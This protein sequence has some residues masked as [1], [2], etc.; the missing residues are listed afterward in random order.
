MWECS[1]FRM[2]ESMTS[3]DV[4]Q[5]KVLFTQLGGVG[6]DA[7]AGLLAMEMDSSRFTARVCLALVL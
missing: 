3:G 1:L 5:I 4:S 7:L 6:N 2:I